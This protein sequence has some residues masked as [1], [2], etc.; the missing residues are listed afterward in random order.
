[1]KNHMDFPQ[2]IIQLSTS[3][4]LPQ[5]S[6]AMVMA[7]M[8]KGNPFCPKLDPE[9]VFATD[10][11]RDLL[12]F[13][14]MGFRAL[15]IIGNP[16]AGKTSIVEQWHARLGLPLFLFPCH[17]NVTEID[18]L[19]Q[20]V[21]QSNGT[22]KWMDSPLLSVYR[23]GGSVLLDEWNNL[24]P[25]AAT[26]L[27]AMLEGYTLTIPQTGEV[28]E[29]HPK[30]RYF[31]TQNPIDGKS[32]VQGRYVQD[33]ASDDRFMEMWV[34]YIEAELEIKVIVSAIRKYD[35]KTSDEAVLKLAEGFVTVANAVRANFVRNDQAENAAFH[36]PLSTR[37]L[38]R[39]AQLT[40]GF[41]T[42]TTEPP[43]LYALK[44]AFSGISAEMRE[45]VEKVIK[46]E[47]GI[48]RD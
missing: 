8:E 16:A 34:D 24:N 12:T 21:P 14:Q 30:A 40:V 46:D 28:I 15:K 44:R 5:L 26:L 41:R 37:V 31:A 19:G 3:F 4:N 11:F 18:L 13:W 17:E 27:N 2:T 45:A 7:G 29:P 6:P 38:K 25:N 9:Y 20:F 32:A 39:W 42:V 43:M 33:S 48:K 22:L 1:M 35:A 23:Y 47:V 10:R 36:K